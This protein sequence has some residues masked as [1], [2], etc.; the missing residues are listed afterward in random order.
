VPENPSLVATC[1]TSAYWCLVLSHVADRKMVALVACMIAEEAKLYV[2]S[3]TSNIYV[4][5][6]ERYQI[7]MSILKAKFE[8][9]NS[10]REALLSTG[11][12]IILDR[13]D[14]E[15]RLGLYLMCI[16]DNMLGKDDWSRFID[17]RTGEFTHSSEWL[18]LVV[19]AKHAVVSEL[20]QSNDLTPSS[21]RDFK[22]VPTKCI[23]TNCP[24]KITIPGFMFC[25]NECSLD[26]CMHLG[27]KEKRMT[28]FGM[29]FSHC[30]P[31]CRDGE[32][33][34]NRH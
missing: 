3:H 2:E 11:N 4:S 27:C 12:T 13:V 18:S 28:T 34:C 15:N 31:H 32:C 5:V 8:R 21:L 14:D 29:K 17:M 19:A 26:L 24:N 25:S 33:E 30:G 16:R 22:R 23:R 1:V 6:A 9:N 7:M 20:P 10:C